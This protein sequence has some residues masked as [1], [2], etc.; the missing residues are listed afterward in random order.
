DVA[1]HLVGID[2]SREMLAKARAKTIYQELI[3]GD[4]APN[5]AALREPA[6]LFLAA[7]V[8]VYVGDLG[9]V[10]AQ[11]ARKSTP[12]AL[13]CFSVETHDGADYVLRDTGRF[14]H[15]RSYVER[16]AAT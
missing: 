7:D 9:D 1:G 6:E 13:F 15:S 11:V 2:L 8:F 10:F 12:Q 16:V 14:A 4:L 5:I 3:E